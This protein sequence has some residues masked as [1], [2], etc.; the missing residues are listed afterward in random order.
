MRSINETVTAAAPK[1]FNLHHSRS[2]LPVEADRAKGTADIK[3]PNYKE[4]DIESL[5]FQGP[6]ARLDVGR[7]TPMAQCA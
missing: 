1:R 7:K 2:T 6:F 4:I 3:L 5:N